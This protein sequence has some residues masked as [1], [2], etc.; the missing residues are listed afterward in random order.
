MICPIIG[1]AI[2][3]MAGWSCSTMLLRYF[4]WRNSMSEPESARIPSIAAVLAHAVQFDG[5]FEESPCRGIVS[6]ST[7]QKVDRGTG[8]VD[9]S[10]QVLPL[11]A[12]FDVGFVHPPV[13]AH[14]TFASAKHRGQERQDIDRPPMNRGVIDEQAALGHHLFDLA[15]AQRVG[16]VPANAHPHHLQRIV[17]PLD[18]LAQR[19]DRPRHPVVSFGSGYL[20]RLIATEPRG[21]VAM[22]YIGG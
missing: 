22:R 9:G 21:R 14:R 7:K 16:R 13:R 15:Q 5:A 4:D 20:H 2:L 19:L 8:R 17:Q 3:L 6:L 10:V 12:D 11:A 1:R 18:H